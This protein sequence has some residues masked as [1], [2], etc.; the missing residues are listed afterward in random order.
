MNFIEPLL[1][2]SFSY[3]RIYWFSVRVH[4]LKVCMKGAALPPQ[5]YHLPVIPWTIALL[6][7]PA[8]IQCTLERKK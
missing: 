2:L 4:P 8:T 6:P 3:A 1:N 5:V 7:P